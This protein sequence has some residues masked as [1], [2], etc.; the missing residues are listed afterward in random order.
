MMTRQ[1]H[2]I[3]QNP[4]IL[5]QEDICVSYANADYGVGQHSPWDFVQ[6]YDPLD[7]DGMLYKFPEALKRHFPQEWENFQ[8]RIYCKS[9]NKA[10]WKE[11]VRCMKCWR[12][13]YWK[14]SESPFARG[15]DEWMR[16]G[17]LIDGTPIVR[18]STR[19][20]TKE[21]G[22]RHLNLGSPRESVVSPSSRCRTA[23]PYSPPVQSGN[24]RIFSAFPQIRQ[25][26]AD[27]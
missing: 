5:S 2:L 9:P 20:L 27:V 21:L 26:D 3:W 25:R 10:R 6:F 16:C 19:N 23:L 7:T 24:R 13:H 4:Y 14:A 22:L 15:G 18:G 1:R 8:V 17:T 12:D 11:L